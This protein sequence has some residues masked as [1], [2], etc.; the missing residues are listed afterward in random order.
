MT[1]AIVGILASM[2]LWGQADPAKLAA[3]QAK[4]PSID[5]LKACEPLTRPK[6]T[7]TEVEHCD[8]SATEFLVN[9][10]HPP[11]GV[12]AAQWKSDRGAVETFADLALGWALASEKRTERVPAALFYLA[13][14]AVY[15]GPAE[16]PDLGRTPLLTYV[17][18]QYENFHG[19]ENGYA[20]FLAMVKTETTPPPDF[21]IRPATGDRD[22]GPVAFSDGIAPSLALWKNLKRALAA[23]DG[24]DYFNAGMKDAL[25]PT[26]K[27]KV[28]RLGAE[29]IPR[30][31][32]L[33]MEDGAPPEVTLKFDV[34]LPGNIE[35]GTVLSF[36]GVAE[37]YTANPFMIVFHVDR[38]KLHR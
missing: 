25:L 19:S 6:P 10:E 15:E 23:P 8:Q 31:I 4:Y 28:V 27:G 29:M 35:P 37:S 38:A 7:A 33:S 11:L 17:R 18:R 5:F 30:T 9:I 13:R 20:E 12:T 16:L 36:E 32:L 2:C 3:W 1:T 24:P 22:P 21:E 34:P 26:L 14:A